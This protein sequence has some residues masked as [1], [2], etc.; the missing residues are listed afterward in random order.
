MECSFFRIIAHFGFM[1]FPTIAEVVAAAALKNFV[2]DPEKTT[3]FLGRESLIQVQGKGLS[4]ISKSVFTVMS[5][6][7]EDAADFFRM[8][9]NRTIEIGLPVEI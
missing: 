9:S 7:A 5:R 8:P 1:E 3:F 6:N 2:I 4:R